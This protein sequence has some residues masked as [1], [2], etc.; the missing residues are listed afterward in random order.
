MR[1]SWKAIK[2]MVWYIILR[3]TFSLFFFQIKLLGKLFIYFTI[4]HFCHAC[5]WG[6]I[7]FKAKRGLYSKSSISFSLN[8]KVSFLPK[9]KIKKTFGAKWLEKQCGV[10]YLKVP[11]S[12][13]CSEISSITS[14]RSH[15]LTSRGFPSGTS[16]KEPC[17]QCRRRT[18]HGFDPWVRKIP[19]RRA[20]PPA[21]VFLPGEPQ[22]QRS[23]RVAKRQTQRKQLSTAQHVNLKNLFS[24]K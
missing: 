1:N 16:G 22:G 15:I 20:W 24:V 13:I 14:K 6:R 2:C 8:S 5:M 12:L 11:I 23:H 4:N 17:C 9:L 21:P 18:R 10:I 7:L 3:P 19:W